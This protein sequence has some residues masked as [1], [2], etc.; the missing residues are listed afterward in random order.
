MGHL[1]DGYN[2][3]WKCLRKGQVHKTPAQFHAAAR[4][5]ALTPEARP[6]P[7]WAAWQLRKPGPQQT[8]QAVLPPAPQEGRPQGPHLG[9]REPTFNQL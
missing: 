2:K 9:S 4:G 1:L 5:G 8:G 6:P 3:K 7:E